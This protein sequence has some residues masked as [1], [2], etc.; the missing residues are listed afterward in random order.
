MCGCGGEKEKEKGKE[1]EKENERRLLTGE[2]AQ[3]GLRRKG[4]TFLLGIQHFTTRPTGVVGS[5]ARL[6]DYTT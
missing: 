4:G 6:E 2:R 3:V 1:K 5:G